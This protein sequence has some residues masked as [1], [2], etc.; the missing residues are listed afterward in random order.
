L[1][2]TVCGTGKIFTTLWIKEKLEATPTL[3]LLPSLGLLSQTL[4]EWT[5]DAKLPFEVLCVC[6]DDT[7]VPVTSARQAR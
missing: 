1:R 3:I 6:S 7:V 4:H 5:L 2:I